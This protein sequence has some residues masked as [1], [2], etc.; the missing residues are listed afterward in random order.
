[1]RQAMK[2]PL[3]W[4]VW[5]VLMMACALV[6][7]G[8]QWFIDDADRDIYS[9]L[10]QRQPQTI[11]YQTDTRIQPDRPARPMGLSDPAYDFVPSPIDDSDIPQG[12]LQPAEADLGVPSTQ[13]ST[14]P[15]KALDDALAQAGPAPRSMGLSELLAFAF[16][17]ARE[18]Q[19]AKEDLY[20]AAL[21]LTLERHLWTPIPSGQVSAEF[22]DF[23]Q[24]RDFD[25]A[26][27]A[28]SELAVQ[29]QLPYG[30]DVTARL[31]NTWMRDLGEHITTGESGQVI[32]EANLPLLRGA[33]PSAYETRYQAERALI[34]Q[35]RTF[36]RFRQQFVVDIAS[37]YYDLLRL[38][39]QVDNAAMSRNS[40]ASDVDR[41]QALFEGNRIIYL[42]VQRA[43]QE[44]LNADTQWITA[45]EAYE[46]AL[47]DFKIRVGMPIDSTVE[48]IDEALPL[49]GFEVDLPVAV[50]T[51]VRHR[52]DLITLRDQI[53]DARRGISIAGN[54]L[55]PDF[56]LT[57]SATMDTDPEHFNTFSYNTERTT[58][59]GTAT[60]EIPLDRKK[61]RNDYRTALIAWRQ[62]CRAY[63]LARDTVKA[64]VQQAVRRIRQAQLTVRNAE[65]GIDVAT[66]RREAAGYQFERGLIPNRD[67]VEAERD[68]LNARDQLALSESGLRRQILQ[69]RL[70]TGTLR[71]NDQGRWLDLPAS[72]Q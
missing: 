63:D 31:V 36:E 1:M 50:D 44:Y 45:K 7:G 27:E 41:A 57:G 5:P 43:Q 11:G 48:I 47:D 23:G 52:L 56:N 10:A 51:A 42:D 26:M 2:S 46:A 17:H 66:K 71:I 38:R 4:R 70:E 37:Q 29:Q 15:A 39:A 58:W 62:A 18:F 35:V 60:L 33:G 6:L 13:P 55:L 69:F 12:F 32:L 59:R 14:Q 22:A 3:N 67:V 40:F 68:L 16:R 21:D 8:C 34:Y 19:T 61:E 64:D 65:L 49:P 54:N 24:V 25:R 30:G 28:V 20:V 53:N 72:D 9:L